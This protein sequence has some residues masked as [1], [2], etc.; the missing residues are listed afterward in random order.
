MTTKITVSMPIIV[1]F[2]ITRLFEETTKL[3]ECSTT[4]FA[5]KYIQK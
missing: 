4:T 5:E 3:P 2:L 1:D